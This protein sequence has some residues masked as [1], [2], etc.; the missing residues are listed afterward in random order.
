[1][2]FKQICY[3]NFDYNL[4]DSL[5][6]S[7]IRFF[8]LL[9]TF[10]WIQLKHYL[11]WYHDEQFLFDED[12]WM[13][14]RFIKKKTTT[15]RFFNYTIQ[16]LLFFILFLPTLNREKSSDSS[17]GIQCIW[18]IVADIICFFYSLNFIQNSNKH[19]HLH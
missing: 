12:S 9:I 7:I 13:L 16:S 14:Q 1:M 2:S 8:M 4:L 19:F 18:N 17:N 6:I 3:K 11:V 10:F 15:N 5:W